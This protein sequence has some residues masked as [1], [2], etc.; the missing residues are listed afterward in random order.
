MS[1]ESAPLM[2]STE[3]DPSVVSLVSV[4]LMVSTELDPSEVSLVSAVLMVS[5]ESAA[6]VDVVASPTAVPTV[7]SPAMAVSDTDVESADT[8]DTADMAD[9]AA[10]EDRIAILAADLM[11]M[12]STMAIDQLASATTAETT[13]SS[14]AT[15]TA[16]LAWAAS[17][18]V[19]ATPEVATVE[20]F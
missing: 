2:L 17:A 15:S 12:P 18:L 20:M 14:L 13:I 9:M 19:T 1:L 4:P 5:V 7:I 10:T 11:L 3:L 16:C 6:S 8:A